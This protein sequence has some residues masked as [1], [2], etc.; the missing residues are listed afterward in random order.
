MWPF[1]SA[2]SLTLAF[3]AGLVVAAAL[4]RWPVMWRVGLIA[5][6]AAAIR[7]DSARQESFH[8]WDERFHVLVAKNLIAHP[9][10]PTLYE[11]P[12]LDPGPE[13]WMETDIWLHK[14]PLAMWLMAG[15]LSIFG[16]EALPARLPSLVLS[17]LGVIL[18]F[19]IGRR[20]FNERVGLVAAFFQAVQGLL[21]NL[22]SGRRVA[23]HVDTTLIFCV[24]LGVWLAVRDRPRNPRWQSLLTGAAIGAALLAKTFPALVVVPIALVYWATT[25]SAARALRRLGW[26]LA[27]VLLIAGPWFTYIHVTFPDEARASAAYTLRHVTEVM[28]GHGGS[29]SSYLTSLPKHYGALIFIPV[30]WLF[31]RGLRRGTPS[32]IVVAVWIAVPIAVFSLMATKLPAFIA[33]A[34]PALML[35]QAHFW[36]AIRDR[37]PLLTG[38]RRPA[39]ITALVLLAILPAQPLLEA[40]GPLERRDRAPA[41]IRELRDLEARLGLPD[42]VIFNMPHAVEAM[43]YTRYT[44]YSRRPSP[45]EIATLLRERRP[46]VIYQPEGAETPVP[47]EWQA[48]VVR[49]VARPY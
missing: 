42:A 21:V 2:T 28:E 16:V 24:Q 32:E 18:T 29:W 22:A 40:T 9:L 36:V 17:T 27:G 33:V 10:R 20:L 13:P 11:R 25:E 30:I 37:V 39:T 14:P 41:F 5:L 23:D 45:E 35:A 1:D 4:T 48:H 44:A 26:T 47:A 7:F 31:A 38:W 8:A 34:A 43:F 15:S 3:V 6:A 12:V 49:G 19:A 46:I